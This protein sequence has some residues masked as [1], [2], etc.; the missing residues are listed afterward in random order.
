VRFNVRSG[1]DTVEPI[2]SYGDLETIGYGKDN[3][4]M[5]NAAATR[6]TLFT[7]RPDP[8]AASASA[9]AQALS[10]S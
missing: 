7:R 8:I 9:A 6:Y 3:V 4:V 1:S 2:P 10:G 5:R